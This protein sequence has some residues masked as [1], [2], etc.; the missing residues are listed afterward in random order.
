MRASK[1]R[2]ILV[3][4]LVILGLAAS[5]AAAGAAD[6]PAIEEYVLTLPG[7]GTVGVADQT[8]AG[9]ELGAPV[10]VTGERRNPGSSLGAIGSA[11]VSPGGLAVVLA[12]LV[13]VGLSIGWRRIP[14]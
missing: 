8:G 7:V 1:S 10:G 11:A 5:P 3:G 9:G 2:S 13:A 14:R 12:L 6:P 4:A